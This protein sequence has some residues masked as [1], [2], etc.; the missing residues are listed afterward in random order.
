[1]Q[2]ILII[3][4]S[5]F[6]GYQLVFRLLNLGY[7]VTTL[8]RGQHPDP[9]GSRI[10]RLQADRTTQAF[11]DVLA[12]RDFDVVVDFAAFNGLDVQGAIHILQDHTGHYIY[13]SSGAV[14]MVLEEAQHPS[15]KI[16]TEA[17]YVGPILEKPT[18]PEDISSWQYGVNKRAGEDALIK[19]WQESKFPATRL[20]L[21]IV[22]GDRDHSRRLESYLWRLMDE[23]PILLPD[24]G[25]QPIRQVYSGDVVKAIT[26]LMTKQVTFGKAYNL[27]QD[28]Q[29]PL[30]QFLAT[31]G[32]LLGTPSRR[33]VDI[34]LADL[35]AADLNLRDV[36]PF[37]GHWSSMVD[38][39]LAKKELGFTHEPL[40]R[41]LDK[42]ISAFL[43]HLPNNPP[44]NYTNR[45]LEIQLAQNLKT[46]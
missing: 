44:M 24:G 42:I 46:K 22:N 1:M 7:Q 27:S 33:M 4:G 9:F 43:N 29:L 30:R 38:P 11:T 23:G 25:H 28:E 18:A 31:L 6:V 13:I 8:N 35:N 20:R 37:S 12:G 26:S 14:Y 45:N 10:E 21:P 2:R 16:W 5:R 32:H 36:S 34:S 40:E 39:S 41:Y 17:Q 3:G 15:S 19:A